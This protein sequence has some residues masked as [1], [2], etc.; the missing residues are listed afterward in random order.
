MLTTVMY[1]CC[2]RS[3]RDGSLHASTD[4]KT[5]ATSL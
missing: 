4:R 5:M 1:S 3:V 2:L